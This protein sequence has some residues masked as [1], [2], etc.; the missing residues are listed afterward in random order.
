MLM[1]ARLERLIS[2]ETKDIKFDRHYE[3]GLWILRKIPKKDKT[4]RKI[5]EDLFLASNMLSSVVK[6]KR[7][8]NHGTEDE[9]KR[10]K[11]PKYY[12]NCC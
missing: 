6:K 4:L 10:M 9:S 7:N 12:F 8:R 5:Q 3:R 11:V 2:I 1:A